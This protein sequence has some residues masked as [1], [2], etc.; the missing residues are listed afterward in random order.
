MEIGNLVRIAEFGIFKGMYGIVIKLD[1]FPG[2]EEG[3]AEVY[4]KDGVY[5]FITEYVV[6][7]NR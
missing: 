2:T 5:P 1:N 7:V 6:V 3:Y 4:V